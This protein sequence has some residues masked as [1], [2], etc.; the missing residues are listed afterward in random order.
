MLA[1]R[2]LLR[3]R[4][5]CLPA[6]GWTCDKAARGAA[7][8]STCPQ[9]VKHAVVA[10]RLQSLR[11]ENGEMFVRAPK[12]S[13]FSFCEISYTKNQWKSPRNLFW[14]E[15]TWHWHDTNELPLFTSGRTDRCF[16]SHFLVISDNTVKRQLQIRYRTSH[17]DPKPEIHSLGTTI[18][19]NW[20]RPAAAMQHPMI[21]PRGRRVQPPSAI[22]H[23]SSIRQIPGANHDKRNVH[24]AVQWSF[25]RSIQSR[26]CCVKPPP[27]PASYFRDRIC[28]IT[29]N[30]IILAALARY[31]AVFAENH[32]LRGAH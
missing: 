4:R 23:L 31:S 5:A 19:H 7:R 11:I 12:S 30:S 25:V 28:L 6:C 13:P 3:R 17:V 10:L 18:F 27:P 8:S 20:L 22:A 26:R 14:Q 24:Y 21:R 32:M 2:L 29:F 1:P 15:R 9:C 16:P